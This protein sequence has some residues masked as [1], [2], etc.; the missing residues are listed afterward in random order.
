MKIWSH[1][2]IKKDLKKAPKMVKERFLEILMDLER[3]EF[4]GERLK[5]KGFPGL[6]FYRVRVGDYR[7]IYVY[8]MEKDE[9]IILIVGH[10]EKI[11]KKYLKRLKG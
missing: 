9:V 7:I 5:S 8:N 2:K 11:Y 1:E 6:L 4:P 10:R 3:G